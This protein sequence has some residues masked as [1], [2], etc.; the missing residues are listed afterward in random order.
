[1]GGWRRKIW[2]YPGMALGFLIGEPYALVYPRQFWES[3]EPYLQKGD[4]PEGA[5]PGIGALLGLQAKN[6]AF[7]G[8]GLPLTLVLLFVFIRWFAGQAFRPFP[9]VRTRGLKETVSRYFQV[10]TNQ[11]RV[12]LALTVASFALSIVLLRQ[13]LLRYALPATVFLIFPAANALSEASLKLWSRGLAIAVL[14]LTAVLSLLQVKIMAQE[15]TVNQA[16]QWIERH[17]PAGASVKKGWPEIPVLNPRKFQVANFF[18]Q[19]RL[20]DFRRYFTDEAGKT[21]FP[22]YVLLDSLPTLDIPPEFFTTLQE[23]YCLVAEF[24]RMPQLGRFKLP[25]WEPP[26]DWRYSHPLVQIYRRRM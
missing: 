23:N 5:V 7:F 19:K 2:F 12:M 25:E 20:A 24:E 21:E 6:M 1:M 15:H 3:I 22:D 11:L 8:F 10:P 9:R 18:A 26:H 14:F 17:V 13:P 16:F 4:L